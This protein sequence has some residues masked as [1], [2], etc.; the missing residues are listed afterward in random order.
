MEQV[1][2]D[3]TPRSDD[4]SL[5]TDPEFPLNKWYRLLKSATEIDGRSIEYNDSTPSLLRR[6]GFVDVHEY[7]VGLPFSMWDKKWPDGYAEV[8]MW[9][10]SCLR[11]EDDKRDSGIEALSLAAFTRILGWSLEQWQRFEKEIVSCILEPDARFYH[12]M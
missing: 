9:Y 2:I 7:T 8:A 11:G 12:V 3:L 1:E 5:P 4:S 10:A 6:L